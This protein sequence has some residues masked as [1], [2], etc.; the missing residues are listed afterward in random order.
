MGTMRR[1]RVM[2]R[3]RKLLKSARSRKAIKNVR[4]F[5]QWREQHRNVSFG[6]SYR[7]W[8]AMGSPS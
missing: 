7:E 1:Q 6:V 2:I 3:E 4:L 5:M 8:V